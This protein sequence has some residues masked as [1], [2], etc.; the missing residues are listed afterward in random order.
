MVIFAFVFTKLNDELPVGAAVVVG[1]PKPYT[2]LFGAVALVA[3][4]ILFVFVAVGWVLSKRLVPVLVAVLAP[5]IPPLVAVLV[6]KPPK[7]VDVAVVVAMGCAPKNDVLVGVDWFP[8]KRLVP[9][10][11]SSKSKN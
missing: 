4:N 6:P 9:V 1:C 3:P 8:P 7:P 2:D 5:N 10:L 11:V